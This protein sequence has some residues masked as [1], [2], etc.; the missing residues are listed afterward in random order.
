MPRQ[1]PKVTKS[2]VLAEKRGKERD[3]GTCSGAETQPPDSLRILYAGWAT[4]IRRAL[5]PPPYPPLGPNPL[6][7]RAV[8]AR[9]HWALFILCFSSTQP[10]F[11]L[12][13]QLRLCCYS[14]SRT[15]P[16]GILLEWVREF[17]ILH[18]GYNVGHC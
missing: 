16:I 12:G 7:T 6:S 13:I 14:R 15:G 17:I 9:L 10:C 3:G 18:C 8:L 2:V 5:P 4:R 1:V 11:Q